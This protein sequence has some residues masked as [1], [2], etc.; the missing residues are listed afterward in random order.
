MR[1]KPTA[2]NKTSLWMERTGGL[3]ALG[4]GAYGLGL[5]IL[6]AGAHGA[7]E[8]M[9]AATVSVALV[10]VGVWVLRRWVHCG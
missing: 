1:N 4:A 6:G 9:L 3:V 8:T 5:V 2:T 10:A 7:D